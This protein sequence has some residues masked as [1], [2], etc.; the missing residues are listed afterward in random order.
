MVDNRASTRKTQNMIAV[1]D[2][3]AERIKALQTKY[4]HTDI[5]DTIDLMLNNI[6]HIQDN[7]PGLIKDE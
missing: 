2:V 5:L 7:I 4:K 6:E 3:Q 1:T